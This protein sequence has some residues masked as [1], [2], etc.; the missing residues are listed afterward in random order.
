MGR[1]LGLGEVQGLRCFL[2]RVGTFLAFVKLVYILG[3]LGWR[4]ALCS[5]IL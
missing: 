2:R 1:G 4:K 3:V 5:G